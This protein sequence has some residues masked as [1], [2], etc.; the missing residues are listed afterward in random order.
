MQRPPPCQRW[1]LKW[2]GSALMKSASS[3]VRAETSGFPC[4]NAFE[5]ICDWF[6]LA[7]QAVQPTQLTV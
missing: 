3:Q 2:N 7:S 5:L 6:A 1:H 4:W